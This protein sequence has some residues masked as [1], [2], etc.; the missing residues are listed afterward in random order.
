MSTISPSLGPSDR[1]IQK[2]YVV[3]LLNYTYIIII[4]NGPAVK[5]VEY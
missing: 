2:V 1:I 3:V 4:G 5:H